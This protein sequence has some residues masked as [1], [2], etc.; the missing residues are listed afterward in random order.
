M[1]TL[2]LTWKL[3]QK[4]QGDRRVDLSKNA[5]SDSVE[6]IQ[7]RTRSVARADARLNG[8]FLQTHE[9]AE[10]FYLRA[11][12]HERFETVTVNAQ[13]GSEHVGSAGGAFPSGPIA[14]TYGFDDIWMNGDGFDICVQQGIDQHACGSF[15]RYD[16]ILNMR[17][18]LDQR[19]DSGLIVRD[20]ESRN[21]L[22]LLVDRANG[23]N[24]TSPIQPREMPQRHIPRRLID[25][26]STR[27][28]TAATQRPV[29]HLTSGH[30]SLRGG[31]HAGSQ[32]TSELGR[33][34][35]GRASASALATPAFAMVHQ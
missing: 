32:A 22:A 23:V 3:P 4:R 16:R 11:V 10:R 35:K 9:H 29:A 1:S 5:S 18:S 26:R 34:S 31:S 8:V 17:Q 7:E 27:S 13:K 20:V 12:R 19:R 33:R 2:R 14:R 21:D 24:A 28:E 6:C 30:P 25:R 15:D